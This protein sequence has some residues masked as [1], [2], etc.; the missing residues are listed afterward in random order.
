VKSTD[1]WRRGGGTVTKKRLRY[2]WLLPVTAG[3]VA[4]AVQWHLG[5]VAREIAEDETHTVAALQLCLRAQ[6]QFHRADRYGNG[7]LVYANPEDGA[8]FPDLYQIGGPGSGGKVLGLIPEAM[9]RA[10]VGGTPWNSY[11]FADI[12]YG[13]YSIDCG[14]TNRIR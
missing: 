4:A 7:F 12:E 14:V 5:A 3:V 8:G 11:V 2:L 10:T 13:D 1:T 6:N 9:A